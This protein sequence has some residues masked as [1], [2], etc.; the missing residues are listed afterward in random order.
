[1]VYSFDLSGYGT[2]QIPEN[3]QNV[4]QIG[5]WSDR[6]F[7]FMKMYESDHSFAVQNIEDRD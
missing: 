7:E 1:M 3:E 6:V 4:V 2:L 5:G